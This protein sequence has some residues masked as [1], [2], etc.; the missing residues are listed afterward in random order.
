MQNC[1]VHRNPSGKA[2]TAWKNDDPEFSS[3]KEGSP[4]SHG[5]HGEERERTS[6]SNLRAEASA[7]AGARDSF[8]LHVLPSSPWLRVKLSLW[9]RFPLAMRYGNAGSRRTFLAA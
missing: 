4:R 3:P 1:A 8:L 9:T 6:A 5:E 2:V 7:K